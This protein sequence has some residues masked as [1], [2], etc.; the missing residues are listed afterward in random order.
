MMVGDVKPTIFVRWIFGVLELVSKA[1]ASA[2]STIDAKFLPRRAFNI[3]WVLNAFEKGDQAC[4]GDGS[5]AACL[6]FAADKLEAAVAPYGDV[7][8]DHYTGVDRENH[9]CL[10]GHGGVSS[11]GHACAV[12]RWG[13]DV[14]KAMFEH[15]ILHTTPLGRLATAQLSTEVTTRLS[16]WGMSARLPTSRRLQDQATAILS[17]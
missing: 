9:V 7:N 4:G 13:V 16:T 6:A 11:H 1:G 12:P 14:H 8:G 10:G 5:A 17:I 3:V 2:P 15:Q